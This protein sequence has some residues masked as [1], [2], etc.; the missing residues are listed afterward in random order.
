MSTPSRRTV[1]KSIGA[2]AFAGPACSG[3]ANTV[4]DARGD[5]AS[6]A[7]DSALSADSPLDTS[8]DA[9]ADTATLA[10]A[11]GGTAAMVNADS[12]PNPFTSGMAR[13]GCALTCA[14]TLGPCYAPSAPVRQDV[15]EGESGV[16]MRLMLRVVEADG[17]TAVAG[18]EV[19]IW[20]C[21]IDGR[22]SGRDVN[23]VAF[24]TGGDAFAEA[25]YFARGRAIADGNGVVTFDATFPG[26]YP[27][28]ALHV[29]FL[30]RREAFVG[31]VQDTQAAIVSQVFFDPDMSENLFASVDGY[32]QAEQP[33]TPLARDGIAQSLP[34]L[35]DY[36]CETA[37]MTDGAMLA[38]RTIAISDDERC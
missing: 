3:S 8:P 6:D 22:Y 18:A 11:T 26:W 7:G 32:I 12:Y 1:L 36:I 25:A 37:R 20:Y 34:T 17:C 4:L 24:C 19:E 29:H 38:W 9:L 30:V 2:I 27:G 5:T 28:R 10:W 14:L 15:S 21:N 35:D 23:Q 16:P 33:D 13:E 31:G